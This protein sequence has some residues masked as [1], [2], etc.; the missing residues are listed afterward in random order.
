MS[1]RK[2]EASALREFFQEQWEHLERLLAVWQMQKSQQRIEEEKLTSAVEFIVDGT[3]AR[4]RGVSSYQ[5]Q[6]R[7]SART[8]LDYTEQLVAR[9]PPA[10]EVNQT[11]LLHNPLART[12]FEGRDKMRRI[13]SQD[14]AIQAFFDAEE[15][16]QREE[17]FALLFLGRKETNI[18][19]A[20]VRGEILMK[21]VMQTAVSFFAHRLMAPAP[22]EEDVRRAMT[23]ILLESVI[24]HLR[25]QI[26]K[27]R[28]SLSAEEIADGLAN[29]N[30]NI[31][32]PE[33]YIDMLSEQMNHPDQLLELQDDL[34]C[35]NSMG[36]R[37]QD[38]NQ[39]SS[40]MLRLSEVTVGE[41]PSS[42]VTLV[43]FPR[44]EL[45]PLSPD[46]AFCQ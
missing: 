11:S 39:E 1:Q 23:K 37:Q 43:R 24:N 30:R 33:V 8:L 21:E 10:L 31:N 22:M 7:V 46:V 9:M 4:L 34:L 35:V 26:T 12:F 2:P 36:I 5:K 14:A 28:Y 25:E 20:E 16:Q 32:N 18:L 45:L 42:V 27:L 40:H 3:D 15:H 29:P 41:G 6:L 13:F 19:G 44:C 17:V 38:G